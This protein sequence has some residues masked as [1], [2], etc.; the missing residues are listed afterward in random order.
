MVAKVEY[1]IKQEYFSYL[2]DLVCDKEHHKVDYTPLLTML[3]GTKFVAVLD[4][5][6]NRMSDGAAL[7]TEF[8]NSEGI[9]EEYSY[10]FDGLE[11]SVLEVLIGIAKRVEYQVGNGMDIDRT[12]ERFWLLLRNL[13]IEKYSADNYKPLNIREKVNI[14]MKR[15]FK[16]NGA[17]SIFPLKN[18]SGDQ[19]KC[20]I[21]VQMN[22]YVWENWLS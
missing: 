13:G 20:E 9:D 2:L 5:D 1:D 11:V 8:L 16:S 4:R 19:R 17:G 10:V 15:K 7:R 3:L 12:N 22:A 6:E 18:P 14:W 21:W